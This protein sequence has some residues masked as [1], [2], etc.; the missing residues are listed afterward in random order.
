MF[1]SIDHEL[2]NDGFRSLSLVRISRRPSRKVSNNR[3]A[4]SRTSGATFFGMVVILLSQ[5]EAART[6]G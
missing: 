3:N 2:T 6:L 1:N 4:R 5:K